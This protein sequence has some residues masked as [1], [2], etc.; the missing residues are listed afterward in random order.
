MSL[1][2]VSARRWTHQSSR[3]MEVWMRFCGGETAGA[4]AQLAALSDLGLLAT[5]MPDGLGGY[6]PFHASVR[7]GLL[8]LA[9]F[10]A[11]KRCR[12]APIETG[13]SP[14]STTRDPRNCRPPRNRNR[15]PAAVN[16]RNNSRVRDLAPRIDYTMRRVRITLVRRAPFP[17]RPATEAENP[18]E[19]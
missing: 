6:P 11:A 16:S 12:S 5:M 3:S 14:S 2:T 10:P 13:P 9:L 7:K 1:A 15:T 8:S 18:N 4:V 19:V 17:F